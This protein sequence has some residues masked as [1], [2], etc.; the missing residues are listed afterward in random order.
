MQT[1]L[2]SSTEAGSPGGPAASVRRAPAAASR[3]AALERRAN[4]K[5][6]HD[7]LLWAHAKQLLPG[8]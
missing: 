4:M 5:V 7:H 3:G 2:V 8:H 6:A 1:H